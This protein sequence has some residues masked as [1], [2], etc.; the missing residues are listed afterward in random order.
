MIEHLEGVASLGRSFLEYDCSWIVAKAKDDLRAVQASPVGTV[1][2]W[3]I[4]RERPIKTLKGPHYQPDSR[5][6]YDARAHLSFVWNI[7]KADKKHFEIAGIC[8]TKMTIVDE[9]QRTPCSELLS[10]TFEMGDKNS[11][12]CHFHA[13]IDWKTCLKEFATP[14]DSA[15]WPSL[16]V[17]RLPSLLLTPGDCLDYLLGE[18]FQDAWP[19]KY[20]ETTPATIGRWKK[21]AETRFV[22]M[23]DA[24]KMAATNSGR[25]SPWIAVKRW[26]PRDA[27][28][29]IGCR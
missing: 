10:W 18:M 22:A 9:A 3:S 28:V 8:S 14:D 15:R 24:T 17:P 20:E 1:M 19:K 26:Y 29:L 21:D 23:L 12:G 5:G 6:G 25:F 7:R 16:D 2:D 27:C 13:Q 4:A 11:P